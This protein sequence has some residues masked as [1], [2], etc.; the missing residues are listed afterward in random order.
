VALTISLP[1]P[2]FFINWKQLGNIV[3]INI[4]PWIFAGLTAISFGMLAARAQ[5]N[6]VLWAIGGGL[7]A[8]V[9]TTVVFGLSRATLIP[10][11]DD[12]IS[13]VRIRAMLLTLLLLLVLGWI[14]T[15]SLHGHL[16]KAWSAFKTSF[17][18]G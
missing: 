4:A 15:N 6:W 17:E 11:S 10:I 14:F 1:W 18:R 2:A 13:H 7:F 3:T 9:V 16:S 12:T 8:L 5:R